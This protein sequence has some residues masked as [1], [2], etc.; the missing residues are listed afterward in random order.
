MI[1]SRLPEA[2]N[3]WAVLI[4]V[5]KFKDPTLSDLPAIAN[6]IRDLAGA[7]TDPSYGGFSP[8]R[9]TIVADPRQVGDLALVG[10]IASQAMDTLLVYY[11]GHGVLDDDGNLY[12]ALG[13]TDAKKGGNPLDY[14][15]LPVT[16][17]IK[18]LSPRRARLNILVL[19]CCFSGLA[20]NSMASVDDLVDARLTLDGIFVL[21]SSPSSD[22]SLAPVGAEYTAFSGELID[23]LRRGLP[24][25][26]ELLTLRVIYESLL[27]TLAAK[28]LPMA[29]R[30]TVSVVDSLALARNPVTGLSEREDGGSV[31]LPQLH[32]SQ[33]K[34][35]TETVRSYRFGAQELQRAL[36]GRERHLPAGMMQAALKRSE[37]QIEAVR[38]PPAS[39]D[40]FKD[41]I[42]PRHHA[43]F[44]AYEGCVAEL[45]QLM[46]S[47]VQVAEPD[48]QALWIRIA[49]ELANRPRNISLDEP[50][51]EASGYP[52]LLISYAIG[53]AALAFDRDELVFDLLLKIK[54]RHLRH[55]DPSLLRA[56]SPRTVA[57]TRIVREWPLW[58]G[59][60]H[61]YPLS[62]HL[63]RALEPAFADLLTQRE[64]W[65]AFEEYELLRSLLELHYLTFSSLGNFAD[66]LMQN[67]TDVV[68]RLSARLSAGSPLLKSG[69]FNGDPQIV[70]AT[71]RRLLALLRHSGGSN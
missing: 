53:I 27:E 24:G 3:S 67:R 35:A 56:L 60:Q 62:R 15:A 8:D 10:Q 7:L 34:I 49:D 20:V 16:S 48:Q 44:A 17:L 43:L 32:V 58:H 52:A 21:A 36:L 54:V 25:G 69:A 38:N 13:E 59:I 11:A 4:G 65:L 41:E 71:V 22:P 39:I 45:A 63:V 14:T 5:T 68:E 66:R 28:Q 33:N 37:R 42:P 30:R 47:G 18:T 9:C 64:Y 1:E 6:N 46:A 19:D 2:G 57:D 29:Q 50:W 40:E 61:S 31:M 55:I 12:L 51:S 23:I 70:Q 26:P